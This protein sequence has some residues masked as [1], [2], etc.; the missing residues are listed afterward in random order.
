MPDRILL[1]N[2]DVLHHEGSNDVLMEGQS[3]AIVIP[4][5]TA[6]GLYV[7]S[8]VVDIGLAINSEV[9]ETGFAVGS[10]TVETGLVINNEVIETGF[11]VGSETI[12]GVRG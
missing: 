9:I 3:T 11:T 4:E 5:R 1:E 10:E 2:G 6:L 8:E 12:T 7:G